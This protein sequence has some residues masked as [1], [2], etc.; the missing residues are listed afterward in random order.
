MTVIS[1]NY[2]I[3]FHAIERKYRI[4]YRFN[5]IIW[6]SSKLDFLYSQWFWM[7]SQWFLCFIEWNPVSEFNVIEWDP[8]DIYVV[9]NGIPNEFNDLLKKNPSEYNV[10]LNGILLNSML[11]NDIPLNYWMEVNSIQCHWKDIH[12]IHCYSEELLW[13]QCNGMESHSK[14]IHVILNEISEW[15]IIL[16]VILVISMFHW[17]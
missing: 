10:I 5:V 6:I 3:E 13:V 14:L 8:N 7:E 12:W 1:L 17:V 11:L 16:T 15:Y 2:L 4:Q 9:L